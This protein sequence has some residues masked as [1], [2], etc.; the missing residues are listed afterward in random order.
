MEIPY[1]YCHC[2]CGQKT[3]FAKKT[4]NTRGRI[5]G[6]PSKFIYGHS[7]K[8]R[9]KQPPAERF[10]LKVAVTAD[11]TECWEWQG[12]KNEFGYGLTSFAEYGKKNLRTHRIAWQI[13]KGEIPDGL[14]VCHR[15]DNP[16]C[17]NPSH[18]FLG[19]HKENMEDMTKKGR[20]HDLKGEQKSQH[21]LTEKQIIEIHQRYSAGGIYQRELAEEYGVHD[22]VICRILKGKTWKH[23]LAA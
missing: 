9:L 6:K 1:G 5:K 23:V 11:T 16:A 21:K 15:C 8:N 4:D 17:V 2:G 20:H 10:W 14:F 13:T 18:L 19:T 22:S 3:E 12:H 7:L